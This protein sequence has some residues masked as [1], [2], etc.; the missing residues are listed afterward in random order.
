MRVDRV[1]YLRW[2]RTPARARSGRAPF[3]V[4]VA[5]TA[6]GTLAMH[7]L[8]PVLPLAAADFGVSRGTIQLAITLYLFGIAGGQLLYGPVSDKFGRR[9]TL[10]VSLGLY[11]VASAV[12]GWAAGI[13]TLL[14]ARIG[15]AVGG[16]GG[17]VLGPR[18]R[19]RQRR[20]RAGRL[21][22][23]LADHGAEPRTRYRPGG[24]RVSR[25]VV[26][27]ALDLCRIGGARRRHVGRRHGWHCRRRRLRAASRARAACSAAIWP[28]CVPALFAAT[29]S[30]A[31]L[32]APASTPI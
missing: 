15:Q 25:R 22:Y 28:C 11:V 4:L 30:A 26:R 2:L 12:A 29:C 6:T 27:L 5:V 9:P 3:W 7:I 32:P 17:L 10:L 21:A 14:V 24:R 8:V 31:P 16:C 1:G 23:G 19:A 18:D 13:A 20:C